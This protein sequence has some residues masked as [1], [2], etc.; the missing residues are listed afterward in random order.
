MIAGRHEHL[1]ATVPIISR[2][3]IAGISGGAAIAVVVGLTGLSPAA[4]SAPGDNKVTICHRT[5]SVT[6]P[7]RMITVSMSAADGVGLSDHT[8][9]DVP[10]DFTATLPPIFDPT[11]SY[12]PSQKYWGDIIP[13]VRTSPGLNWTA[14][15]AQ[16]IYS[17]IGAGYGLCSRMSAKQFFDAEVAALPD[18]LTPEQRSAALD[19]TLADLDEQG[20]FDDEAA[21]DELGISNFSELDPAALPT[22]FENLPSRPRGPRPPAGYLPEDGRQKL[23]VLVWW[24]ADRDGE[25]DTDELPAANITVGVQPLLVDVTAS[26]L[27]PVVGTMTTDANGL[28][29]IDSLAAGQWDVTATPPTGSDVTWDS[30]GVTDDGAAQADVPANSAGFA[31]VGLVPV[32]GPGGGDSGGTLAATGTSAATP[33][34]G[35]VSALLIALG[36]ALL[37]TRTGPRTRRAAR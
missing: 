20:A 25:Y 21:K 3:I 15:G 26:A 23:A 29:I 7:Y 17:G 35:A 5:H 2:R 37:R 31:W 33:L 19:E 34:L 22:A 8:S 6:N 10:A 16:A 24:D 30:E 11:F 12:T 9:H 13:P 28:V 14:A 32:A 27:A 1:G 36:V 18:G 4:M